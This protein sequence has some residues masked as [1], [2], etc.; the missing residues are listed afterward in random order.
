MDLF[1]I[2]LILTTISAMLMVF[3]LINL[4]KASKLL[5]SVKSLSEP[6]IYEKKIR[7]RKRYLVFTAICEDK[8]SKNSLEKSVES[9]M[10]EY[11]GKSMVNKASPYLVFFDETSQ[12]GIYRIVH[13]YLNFLIATLGLV[14]IIDGKKCVLIP[15]K[16]TGTLKKAHEI[17]R[18]IRY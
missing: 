13:L 4:F 9:K 2:V 15:L 5:K 8:I 7:L 12:R 11:Y 1:K 17:L 18:K 3:S 14:K 16:T 6:T 10:I